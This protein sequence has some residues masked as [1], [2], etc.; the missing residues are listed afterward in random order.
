MKIAQIA[1]LFENVPPKTYGGTERVVH[2]LTEGLV[3]EGHD[4]TLFA[5]D[6]SFLFGSHIISHGYCIFQYNHELSFIALNC[7]HE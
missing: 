7:I 4:V 2:Y 5:T 3:Q 1:P 6:D